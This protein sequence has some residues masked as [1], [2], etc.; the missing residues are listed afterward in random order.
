MLM[1][2]HML[3]AG[4]HSGARRVAGLL[5]RLARRWTRLLQPCASGLA[6]MSLA[7]QRMVSRV[8][9]TYPF[10]LNMMERPMSYK[11]FIAAAVAATMS[12]SAHA[13]QPAAT[14]TDVATAQARVLTAIP[15]NA[16]TV[17]NYY[18]Q[19]VY[20]PSDSKIGEI[21]DVL[22]GD[23]GK[24]DAFIVS[25]G[26]FLGMDTKDVAVPFN[27]VRATQKSG[28]WYLTMNASKDAP[29]RRA[30]N[31]TRRPQTG[32]RPSRH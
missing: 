28:S 18:K 20:D 17:T 30:T 14:T 8:V 11:Y 31:T 3:D 5:L 16:T 4:A 25:V 21:I 7:E 24:I 12:G 6:S 27:A 19:N 29:M 15:S 13:Q 9:G 1:A 10:N 23:D 26:G 32:F 22:V 2:K